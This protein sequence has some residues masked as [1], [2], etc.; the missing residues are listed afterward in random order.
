MDLKLITNGVVKT[1]DGREFT[2]LVGGFGE[3]KPVI[4]DKQ[5]AELLGYKKG[6]RQVRDQVNNNIKYFG[7]DDIIDIKQR[8]DATSTLENAGYAKQSITQANNIYI[9]SQ[10]GFLLYLKFAEGDKAVELYKDFIED[11]FKTKVENVIIKKTLAE[12]LEFLKDEKKFILGNMFLE[13]DE[14]KKIQ[15]FNRNEEINNRMTAIR[16]SLSEENLLKQLSPKISA[17]DKLIGLDG[18]WS[19]GTFS[20]ILGIKNFGR[21]KFFEWLRDKNILM[22]NNEPYQKYVE[23]FKVIVVDNKHNNYSDNKTLIR[24]KGI[25]FLFQKLI[26]DGTVIPKTLDEIKKELNKSNSVTT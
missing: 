12:E 8:G 16:I 1:K 19:I 6:A 11:Y 5:L 20:K 23:Y 18:A 15:L 24:P 3:D 13:E 17:A 2:K 9:F 7:E 14:T 4:T 21:N 22:A 26:A 10:A 25:E